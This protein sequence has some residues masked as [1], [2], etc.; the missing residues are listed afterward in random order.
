MDNA[1][2]FLRT[3]ERAA[4]ASE[5]R[6]LAECSPAPNMRVVALERMVT[7]TCGT[8]MVSLW[9]WNR[10]TMRLRGSASMACLRPLTNFL[11]C[12]GTILEA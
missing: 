11:K 9:M 12:D 10:I 7:A 4:A 2:L 1:S 6:L 5:T 3:V 8:S